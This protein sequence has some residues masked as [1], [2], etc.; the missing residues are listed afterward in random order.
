MVRPDA[1][2]YVAGQHDEVDSLVV[3]KLKK[4][5]LLRRLGLRRDRPVVER[6][7]VRGDELVCVA[8]IGDDRGH[9]D[10]QFA[11]ALPVQQIREAVI[12]A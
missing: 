3:D 5:L 7:V 6:N 11:D 4:L 1:L 12:E 9:L 10:V 8:V 2:S